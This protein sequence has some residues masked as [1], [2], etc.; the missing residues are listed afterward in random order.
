MAEHILVINKRH[1]DD[2]LISTAALN[3]LRH[4]RPEADITVVVPHACAPLLDSYAILN[5]VVGERLPRT[6]F[7]KSFHKTISVLRYRRARYGTCFLF[8]ESL[9]NAK[10]L[11]MFANI[12]ERI[13]A[14]ADMNG[15]PNET[16][17]F[18]TCTVE[19]GSVWTVHAADYFQKGL[20]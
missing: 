16:A 6:R 11:Q 9:T 1:L 13:W 4:I 15:R 19:A 2:V 20:S 18:C 8:G 10:R 17:P 3:L 14:A 7:L 12:P 5:K